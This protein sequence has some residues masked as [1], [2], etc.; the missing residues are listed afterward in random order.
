MTKQRG[1][2]LLCCGMVTYDFLIVVERYPAE[3]SKVPALKSV[4]AVGGPIGRAAITAARLGARTVLAGMVGTGVYADLLTHSLNGEAVQVNL[5]V[6]GSTASSQHS[7]NIISQDNGNRT[8]IWTSQPSATAELI[9]ISERALIESSVVL[10]DC[11]DCEFALHIAGRA[12]DLQCGTV[13]DTGS[14]KPLA[15]NILPFIDYIVAPEKFMI[16]RHRGQHDPVEYGLRSVR[17]QFSPKAVIVTEGERGGRY[18]LSESDDVH[19]FDAVPVLAQDTCGAGDTFHG[20]F[21]FAIYA[22]HGL[23]YAIR[24]AA[25]AAAQ[26]CS[27]LGNI[28]LPDVAAL[29]KWQRSASVER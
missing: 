6:D 26:K 17:H 2:Q 28:S 20:A 4:V 21:A 29:A 1:N 25:W 27:G 7:I 19:H 18:I 9:A 13:I 11:T 23:R 5:V 16:E 22:G 3:D 24:L 15:E 14:Y 12:K 10:V 8:N